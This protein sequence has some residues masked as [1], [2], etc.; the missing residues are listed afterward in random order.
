MSQ[1][2]YSYYK[3]RIRLKIT[4]GIDTIFQLSFSTKLE[5]HLEDGYYIFSKKVINEWL[6]KN[7]IYSDNWNHSREFKVSYG[8]KYLI[9]RTISF[10][11]E[12]IDEIYKFVKIR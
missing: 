10:R 7:G 1:K 9:P 6:R 2:K 8:K 3:V 5:S 11:F 4:N 12:T